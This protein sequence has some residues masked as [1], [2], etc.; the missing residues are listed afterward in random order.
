MRRQAHAHELLIEN[1]RRPTAVADPCELLR[2]CIV[3]P[4]REQDGGMPMQR[5]RAAVLL[6]WITFALGTVAPLAWYPQPLLASL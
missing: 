2:R 4:S 6:A 1:A 3:E 5:V